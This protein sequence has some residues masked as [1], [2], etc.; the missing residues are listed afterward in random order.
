[1]RVRMQ[2]DAHSSQTP[3]CGI[4]TGRLPA[5]TSSQTQ[6]RRRLTREDVM[7]VAEVSAMLGLPRSTVYDLARRGEL[8]CARL[9]RALRFVRDD[10]EARLRGF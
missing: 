5:E 3:G 10:I 2:S 6:P 9:G 4:E 7:T 8:P 1:M